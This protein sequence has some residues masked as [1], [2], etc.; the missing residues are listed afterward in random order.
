MESEMEHTALFSSYEEKRKY[1][2]YQLKIFLF[3]ALFF[4]IALFFVFCWAKPLLASFEPSQEAPSGFNFQSDINYP[5]VHNLPSV[6]DSPP[7]EIHTPPHS[8]P[9]PYSPPPSYSDIYNT[10]AVVI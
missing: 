2:I 7:S 9:P 4:A 5:L 3:I 6:V 1:E 10:N 8:P